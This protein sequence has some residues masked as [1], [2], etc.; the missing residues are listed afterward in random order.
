LHYLHAWVKWWTNTTS[1]A[2]NAKARCFVEQ[3]GNFSVLG[4]DGKA[5][6]VN[7]QLT[8][9]ENIADNGGLKQSFEAWQERFNADKNGRR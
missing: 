3:Y 2:F 7:G 1:E 4:S 8:L 9:G 6:Y 5:Y